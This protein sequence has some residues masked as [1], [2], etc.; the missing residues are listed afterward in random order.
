MLI[1]AADEFGNVFLNISGEGK[2]GGEKNFPDTSMKLIQGI[3]N[4]PLQVSVHGSGR[5][6]K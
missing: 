1:H 5:Y 3:Q 6:L 4:W 2:S